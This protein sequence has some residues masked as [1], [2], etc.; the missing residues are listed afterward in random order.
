MHPVDIFLTSWRR[1]DFIKQTIESIHERTTAGT[2]KIH[3]LDNES[4]SESRA[5]LS[6]Y[7]DDGRVESILFHRTNT[8]CLW[9]KA[10]FHA[11][12]NST[13]PYY[14]V[15]D[16]DVLAPKLTPDWLSQMVGLMDE[17]KDL[18]FLTPQLPPQ[19][20]QEPYA[21]DGKV[22]YCKAVGNTFKMVRREA[23]P[24]GMYRQDTESFGD[25]GLVCSLVHEKGYKVAFCRN[26]FCL[27]LGQTF[28]WGYNSEDLKDDPRKQGYGAPFTYKVLD[29]DTYTPEDIWRI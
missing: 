17:Y 22:V 15:S 18:A 16:N 23:Y 4:T 12:V 5:V 21:K 14:I 2:F 25:D 24:L 10:V 1:P 27:H 19:S 7:L 26:I 8:R 6:P 28:N 9:G 11:M 29:N 3:I 20:L 13:S